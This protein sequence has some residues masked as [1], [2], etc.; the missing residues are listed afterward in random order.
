MPRSD[1]RGD[2]P[3][4]E[5]RVVRA[6]RAA[7]CTNLQILCGPYRNPLVDCWHCSVHRRS[8]ALLPH[9]DTGTDRDLAAGGLPIIMEHNAQGSRLF[10]TL[11]VAAGVVVFWQPVAAVCVPAAPHARHPT[12][13][14]C[15]DNGKLLVCFAIRQ[16]DTVV[17]NL[18]ANALPNGY[19]PTDL[20][21]AYGLTSTGSAAMTV[22]IVDA[23][24]DP[25]AESDLATY[26]STFKLPA[27]TTA[28]GCFRKANQSGQANPLPRTDTGW[29][30]EIS[31]DLDMVSAICPS[32][33]ILLIE[34]SNSSTTNL[35][36][37]V[38]TA[39]NLGAKFVSNS[40][41]G[42][43]DDSENRD[44]TSYFNHPGVV[45]TASTGDDQFDV[46]YTASG[47]GV[48]AVGGTTLTRD[49]STRGWSE[50]VWNSIDSGCS[51][52]VAK[53]ALQTA[54]TTG[55]AERAEADLAAIADPQTGVAV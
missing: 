11:A 46:S 15:P 20:R 29:A 36:T 5:V 10:A 43:E 1:P 52:S 37:A 49:T 35:G 2:W 45:I 27:C 13:R 26:R 33:D 23:F 55:C 7:P 17:P 38:N 9:A 28:N 54:L 31:L 22:A 48:T 40:Y 3:R 30:G 44:D 34:A 47:K 24:D 39:V 51:G 14:V 6:Q 25:N 21:D 8:P 41:G 18:A 42:P 50:T 16:T 4:H 53:P 19:G 12:A 32:C